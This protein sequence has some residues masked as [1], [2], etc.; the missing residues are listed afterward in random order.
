MTKKEV[1]DILKIWFGVCY[2]EFNMDEDDFEALKIL[3]KLLLDKE[4]E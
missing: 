3:K 4:D 1:Y 2:N